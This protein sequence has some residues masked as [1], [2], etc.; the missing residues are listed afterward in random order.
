M[1]SN[2]RHRRA[3][4]A[5]PRRSSVSDRPLTARPGTGRTRRPYSAYS[6]KGDEADGPKYDHPTTK[7]EWWRFYLKETP[8]PGTY[9]LGSFLDEL[10]KKSGGSRAFRAPGRKKIPGAQER[11]GEVLLPGAYNSSD[12]LT[13][14]SKKIETF[15]FKAIDRE[16]G[17]KIGH[18]YGD[19]EIYTEPTQY[20][21][22]DYSG[23]ARDKNKKTST[24]KDSTKRT[25]PSFAFRVVE[26]PGPGKYEYIKKEDRTS[27]S[28]FKSSVPRFKT[29]AT[30][31]PGPGTYNIAGSQPF[32]SASLMHLSKKH[33]LVFESK[34]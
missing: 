3:M 7:R 32:S 25:L 15:G 13:E 19:K 24:F 34:T 11:S 8:T 27:S 16:S 5:V 28:T 10:S 23:G 26:G 12:F 33:G 2:E 6:N 29:S 20:D 30:A 31:T 9:R 4:S 22:V 18:G 17:P 21:V 14:S 1:D